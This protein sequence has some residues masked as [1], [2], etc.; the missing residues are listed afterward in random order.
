MER[1][2][3]IRQASVRVIARNTDFNGVDID[4]NN[5]GGIIRATRSVNYP[6]GHP[7]QGNI[8]FCTCMTF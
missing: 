3:N 5:S 6:C 4:Q 8:P 1:Q 7:V 2:Q